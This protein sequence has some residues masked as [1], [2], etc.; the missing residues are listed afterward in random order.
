M[1]WCLSDACMNEAVTSIAR[2]INVSLSM[3]STLTQSCPVVVWRLSTYGQNRPAIARQLHTCL[4]GNR[5]RSSKLHV[6]DMHSCHAMHGELGKAQK[7]A[8]FT[9]CSRPV[10]IFS[11]TSGGF[12][13]LLACSSSTFRSAA[14]TYDLISRGKATACWAQGHQMPINLL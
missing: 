5:W 8:I 12:L 10:T 13:V 1:F 11:M 6:S 7:W 9:F 14:T 3:V 2:V 4:C